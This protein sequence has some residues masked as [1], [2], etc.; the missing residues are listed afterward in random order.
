MPIL[1][2]I[3]ASNFQS[4]NKCLLKAYYVPVSVV[5]AVNT[6]VMPGCLWSTSK[7][8]SIHL[9]GLSYTHTTATSNSYRPKNER[10]V[11]A[12]CDAITCQ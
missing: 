6:E 4:S 1:I 9:L 7:L 3:H 10:K 8:F 11:I 5:C 12:K 2:L